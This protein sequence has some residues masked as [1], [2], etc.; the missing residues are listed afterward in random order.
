VLLRMDALAQTVSA[1]AGFGPNGSLS[2]EAE[3]LCNRYSRDFA[4]PR[5]S[6]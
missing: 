6:N 2:D 4:R 1:R 5:S 3:M